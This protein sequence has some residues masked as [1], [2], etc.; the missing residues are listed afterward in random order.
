[1][2]LFE[3]WSAFEEYTIREELKAALVDAYHQHGAGLVLEAIDSF[4]DVA[5]A[6]EAYDRWEWEGDL[7]AI[8]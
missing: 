6:E 2:T 4:T 7:H 8:G 1:M 3:T 5:A